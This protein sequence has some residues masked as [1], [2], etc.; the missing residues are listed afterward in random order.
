MEDVIA[1]FC[2]GAEL[3]AAVDVVAVAIAAAIVAFDGVVVACVVVVC[4][5][6]VVAAGAGNRIAPVDTTSGD[7]PLVLIVT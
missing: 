3:V 4:V 2:V 7:V 6:V 1:G 5:A